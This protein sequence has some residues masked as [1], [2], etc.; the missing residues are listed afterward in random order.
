MQPKVCLVLFSFSNFNRAW[1]QILRN[2][3]I[4]YTLCIATNGATSANIQTPQGVFAA[5]SP[6]LRGCSTR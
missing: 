4:D 3:G 1:T 6:D 5:N 2:L